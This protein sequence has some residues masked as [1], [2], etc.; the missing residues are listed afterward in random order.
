[1][2]TNRFRK[3]LPMLDLDDGLEMAGAGAEE[4][5]VAE[6]AD[7]EGA[8]EAEV[9]DLPDEKEAGGRSA[10]EAFADMRRRAEES[11]RMVAELTRQKE[12]YEAALGLF[13][14]G[15]NKAAQAQA[16]HDGIPVEQVLKDMI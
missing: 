10:D 9:A 6:P 2:F 8:E 15:E 3:F 13:F 16:Y 5:E 14:D 11:E 7:E 4:S 1:M 12:E